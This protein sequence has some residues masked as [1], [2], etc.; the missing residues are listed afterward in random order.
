MCNCK[1]GCADGAIVMIPSEIF[2]HTC[3]E[4]QEVTIDPCILRVIEYLW[5]DGW[6]TLGCCC[7]HNKAAPSIV[8]A[9]SYND[10]EV[11]EIKNRI[12]SIDNRRWELMQWRLIEVGK[13]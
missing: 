9:E 2:K 1:P 4:N 13:G 8:L 11:R 6:V 5:D 7:G 12:A 3:R 10:I